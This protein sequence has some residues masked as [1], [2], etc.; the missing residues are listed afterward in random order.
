M[1]LEHS[2]GDTRAITG[3]PKSTFD[4]INVIPPRPTW[5][6][7]PM[8][9]MTCNTISVVKW[10]FMKLKCDHTYHMSGNPELTPLA[11]R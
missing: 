9:T 8:Y 2:K 11:S 4:I 7:H 1:L 3:R 10:L 5:S 6:Q